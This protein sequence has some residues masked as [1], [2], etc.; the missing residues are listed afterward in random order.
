[1]NAAFRDALEDINSSNFFWVWEMDWKEQS[2]LKRNTS[3][4]AE[5]CILSGSLQNHMGWTLSLR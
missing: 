1:M 2:L 3:G 5:V 4:C